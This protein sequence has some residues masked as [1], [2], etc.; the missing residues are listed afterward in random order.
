MKKE[1]KPVPVLYTT[2]T[3]GSLYRNGSV[4]Q[5]LYF[6]LEPD[7][8]LMAQDPAYAAY[9][10][11][12]MS[13]EIFQAITNKFVVSQPLKVTNDRIPFVIFKSNIDPYSLEEFCKAIVQEFSFHT[14]K[15]H[16][17]RYGLQKAMFREIDNKPT[18]SLMSTGEKISRMKDFDSTWHY[19]DYNKD[20]TDQGIMVP[21]EIWKEEK[22]REEA[23]RK[24]EEEEI[25]EW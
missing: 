6:Y 25:V 18:F 21:F 22:R 4:N 19:L 12:M 24:K 17:G 13:T 7:Q 23:A 2:S 3:R 8:E 9:Y 15:E 1:K 11:D 20:L 5:T 16:Q 14:G 10:E